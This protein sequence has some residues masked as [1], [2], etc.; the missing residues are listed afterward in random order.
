MSSIGILGTLPFTCS[1][2]M[3]LTFRD[4]QVE[5]SSRWG[6]HE[7]IGRKPVLEYLGPQLRTVSFTIPLTAFLVRSTLGVL[8]LIEQMVDSKEPQRLLIGPEYFGK[9][10]VESI[11]E[12]RTHHTGLGVPVAATV[13]INLREAA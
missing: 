2:E 4:L 12:S 10:V 9:F 6:T 7:V 11:S 13:T 3:V 1:Q 5:R 8:K